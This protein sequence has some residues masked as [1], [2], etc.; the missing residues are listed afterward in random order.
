MRAEREARG[1]AAAGLCAY[2]LG[3]FDEAHSTFR[4]CVALAPGSAEC[5][6][7][8]GRA[9]EALG[10]ASEA[11]RDYSRALALDPNLTPALLNRAALAHKKGAYDDAIAD[12]GRAL[13]SASVAGIKSQVEYNLNLALAHLAKG[14]RAAALPHAREA[15]DRGHQDAAKLVDRLQDAG[16]K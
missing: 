9:A 15:A 14:D 12:L 8:R 3:R 16:G 10:R 6:F 7:N 2:R 4:V 11:A 5:Y 1:G 13:S